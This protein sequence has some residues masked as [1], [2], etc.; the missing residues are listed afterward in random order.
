VLPGICVFAD[1][2]LLHYPMLGSLTPL[3]LQAV[4]QLP[5]GA[6]DPWHLQKDAKYP[7]MQGSLSPLYLQAVRQLPD[8]EGLPSICAFADGLP[9]CTYPMMQGS[10]S[11]LYLHVV[12]QLPIGNRCCRTP[13]YLNICRQFANYPGVSGFHGTCR[14]MPITD[15]GGLPVTFI[16][17]GG[18]PVAGACWHLCICRWLPITR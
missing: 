17:A 14:M 8:G 10:L 5:G 11:P 16:F 2:C 18:F 15:D 6:V 4:F 3:Y 1:G 13:C 12:C 9:I 7:M